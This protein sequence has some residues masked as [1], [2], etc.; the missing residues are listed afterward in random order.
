MKSRVLSAWLTLL[1]AVACDAAVFHVSPSGDDSAAG[2][3]AAPFKSILRARDALREIRQ[4]PDQPPA[5]HRIILHAGTHYLGQTLVLSHEDSG[6]A[7]SPVIYAAAPDA[8]VIL[9]GA[10]PLALTWSDYRNGIVKAQVPSAKEGK[11][12]FDQFYVNGKSQPLARYPN[13]DA[14]AQYF[15]GTA[16]DA[17]AADRVRKWAR[18]ETGILHAMHGA[19][20]GDAHWRIKSIDPRGN[21][22]L[23]GGWQNNRPSPPHKQHRFI[24]NVFEELDA[25]G[26]WF[27]DQ[28]TGIL[29]F[30]PPAGFNAAGAVYEAP[31][32]KHLVELRGT[33]D[34]PVQF[35]RFEGISFEQSARTFME[36][37][38][39]LLRSDWCIY[40]GA[41]VLLEGTQDCAIADCNF[42]KLGGNAVFVSRYNRRASISGSRFTDI[43]ASCVSFVGD[44]GAVRMTDVKNYNDAVDW[45]KLDRTPGPKTD[46]YPADCRVSDCLMFHFGTVEKQVAGVQISMAARITASHC[47]I[48]DCPRAGINIGDGCWGGHVIEFCD[49]FDTVKETGDHG[50]FNS[51]GRD[52]FWRING[53]P[54]PDAIKEIPDLVKLD[55]VE[56]IIIR[57]SRWRCDHGWDIDLDDGSTHY[58]IQNNL[59]LHGGIK[60]REGFH[61]TV[62]NNIMAFN[63]F[64]PHVWYPDSG[65][66]FRR[67]IVQTAYK[68]I[69][70]AQWGKE[71]DYNLFPDDKALEAARRNGTD[72]NSLAGDALF[73][74]P[75]T[76]DFTVRDGSPALKLG[77]KNFPM[78]QFGVTSPRLKK[79]A[80]TPSFSAGKVEVA[81]R[82][83]AVRPFLGGR[84]KNVVGLGEVS[85][86]GLP[87]ETGV[88]IIEPGKPLAAAAIKPG[89]VIIA[90][91][92]KKVDTVDDLLRLVDASRTAEVE[93]TIFRD[94]SPV[95]VRITRP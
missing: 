34:K 24:E 45:D 56:P 75:Q 41:A 67:N 62:E 21:P 7:Q 79:E 16:A 18:P 1:L 51:W 32:L 65:D 78:D 94:Q 22:V 61:R 54:L 71:V 31:V 46:D 2:T 6:T 37:N 58:I 87:G 5:E 28:P 8:K 20:W 27:L 64:H 86:S 26:E 91:S 76:G 80:K 17:I 57:N 15:N 60:N 33:R 88:I 89:E 85:A 44:P 77:F 82:D 68:P 42:E 74:S 49:V 4:K 81:K 10:A 43:G 48:Y 59:C 55:V 63:T 11:L 47:S 38:E 40:R 84:V 92:D 69:R 52:R 72:K 30:K 53:K 70:V 23:E 35:V 83:P 90:C 29:Y 25:P 66:I 73:V 3:Q 19:H 36:T 50:S 95:K 39:P 9:S 14:N 13:F 93:L 12:S